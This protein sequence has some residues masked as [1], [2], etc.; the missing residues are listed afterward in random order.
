M[1]KV[2]IVEDDLALMEAISKG[3][4][5]NDFTIL[6]AKDGEDGLKIAEQERPN[7]IL[8]DLMMPK[9]DGV[10][11]LKKMR[12]TDWGKDISVIILTNNEQEVAAAVENKVFEYLIKS[13]WKIEDVLKKVKTELRYA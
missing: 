3:L 9:M 12:A 13:N 5:G 2:L 11:M 10:T 6:T 1:K 8:L 4:S 7:L